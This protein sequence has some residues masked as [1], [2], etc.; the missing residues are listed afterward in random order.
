MTH[1][2]LIYYTLFNSIY[3]SVMFN[4]YEYIGCLGWVLTHPQVDTP[5]R[6]REE[7]ESTEDNPVLPQVTDIDGISAA[8]MNIWAQWRKHSNE[9]KNLISQQEILPEIL[10]GTCWYDCSIDSHSIESDP[11]DPRV[12][13][14]TSH[15]VIRMPTDGI[16]TVRFG[17]FNRDKMFP[18]ADEL[19]I[20][21]VERYSS[22]LVLRSSLIST[23]GEAWDSHSSISV[24]ALTE[25]PWLSLKDCEAM[26]PLV[27][28][29]L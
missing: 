16:T 10:W 28:G 12:S 23:T 17:G 22:H 9:K 29:V 3:T 5:E 4:K 21:L 14:V 18:N 25:R 26:N 11:V 8:V 24:A 19:D 1:N 13:N 15:T 6:F 27:E 20:F 7:T 2:M